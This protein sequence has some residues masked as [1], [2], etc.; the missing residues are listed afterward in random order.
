M[1]L[2]LTFDNPVNLTIL[3]K[4]K[5]K[6]LTICQTLPFDYVLRY[7]ISIHTGR[8][9]TPSSNLQVKNGDFVSF[10]Y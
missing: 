6:F 3:R 7:P 1:T 2:L 10:V 4:C 9:L 5:K 8:Q